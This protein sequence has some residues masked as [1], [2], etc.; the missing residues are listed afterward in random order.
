VSVN[1]IEKC[2]ATNEIIRQEIGMIARIEEMA[3][4][5]KVAWEWKRV[6]NTEC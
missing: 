4:G 3:D 5:R 6:T 2:K 1:A